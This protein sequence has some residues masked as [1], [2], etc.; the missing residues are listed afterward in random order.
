MFVKKE[1]IPRVKMFKGRESMFK[2][3]RSIIKRNVNASPPNI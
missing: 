1:N 3:G 2:I